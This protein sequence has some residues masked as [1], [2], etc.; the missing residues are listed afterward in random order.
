MVEI[1]EKSY[2][3]HPNLS[4]SSWDDITFEELYGDITLEQPK[5]VDFTVGIQILK[6]R[7]MENCIWIKKVQDSG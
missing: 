7:K 4:C 3:N 1:H 5:S 2:V 6:D